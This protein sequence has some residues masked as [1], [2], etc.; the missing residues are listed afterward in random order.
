M[1]IQPAPSIRA[2]SPSLP[3][4]PLGAIT[5]FVVGGVLGS[6]MFRGLGGGA[7]I[8]FLD[9]FAL[10]CGF[11]LFVSFMRRRAD[12]PPHPWAAVA[13]SAMIVD[14]V[15]APAELGRI[16]QPATAAD[17]GRGLRQVKATDPGLDLTDF[18]VWAQHTFRV[19]QDAVSARDVG[20][21]RE[22]M[23][24]D[25]FEALVGYCERLRA[26]RHTVRRLRIDVRDADLAAIWQEGGSDYVGVRLAATLFDFTVED[27]TGLVVGGS[28]TVLKELHEDWIFTRPSGNFHWRLCATKSR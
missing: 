15:P 11:A 8:G 20:P 23:T 25:V 6:V 18:A 22:D 12:A 24:A 17:L 7:A 5:G 1:V 28:R 3:N 21:L 19:V 4:T 2:V 9:L 14:H 27:T 26:A 13:R 10:G 16:A